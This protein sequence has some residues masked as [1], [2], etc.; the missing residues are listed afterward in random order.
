MIAQI[1][2]LSTRVVAAA[3]STWVPVAAVGTET[4]VATR[5]GG[6]VLP[7]PSTSRPESST[8]PTRFLPSEAA[9]PEH[10][11]SKVAMTRGW[12]MLFVSALLGAD[13]AF[14]RLPE[15]LLIVALLI[16]AHIGVGLIATAAVVAFRTSFSIPEFVMMAS[17]FLGGVYWPTSAIPSWIRQVSEALPISYGLRALRLAL[18]EGRPLS[19]IAGDVSALAGYGS[20]LMVVGILALTRALAYARGRGTL[21]QYL[22][23]I[24]ISEPTRPY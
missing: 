23:L 19:A 2:P 1:M 6:V 3:A 5:A 15:I 17:S 12:I 9:V 16:V 8:T 11:W 18:L 22:S 21:S 14:Q 20:L 24:H 10:N 13:L 7:S 4:Q